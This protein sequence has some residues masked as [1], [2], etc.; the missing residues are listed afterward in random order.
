M[1]ADLND[2]DDTVGVLGT[3]VGTTVTKE[4]TTIRIAQSAGITNPAT[5]GQYPITISDDPD[6]A[7][8]D[9]VDAQNVADVIRE[10]K[11]SPTSG[12]GGADVTVTGT[13][14]GGESATVFIDTT[15]EVAADPDDDEGMPKS[16]ESNN[17]YDP[18]DD[19]NLGTVDI[20]NGKFTLVTDGIVRPS[21]DDSVGE[22]Y[23]NAI[24]GNNALVET[25]G[26]AKYEFKAGISV[27][28][29]TASWGETITVSLADWTFGDVTH[30]RFGGTNKVAVKAADDAQVEAV[31]PSGLRTGKLKVEVF[32]NT[33]NLQ[34]ASS[35]VEITPL[36][37]TISPS[38]VVPGQQI[39]ITGSGYEGTEEIDS[40]EVGTTTYTPE[41][42]STT[43]GGG[44]T[45]TVDVPLNVGTGDKTVSL[46]V[47]MRTGE[48][49]ITVAS[50]SISLSPAESL[51]GSTVQVTGSGFAADGRILLDYGTVTSLQIGQAG[52][53]GAVNMSFEVPAGAGIGA[54][55][56]VE[57]YVIGSP[58]IKADAKHSTP[59]P[60]LTTTSPVQAG[61]QMTISGSNFK[62]FSTLSDIR[63]GGQNVLPAPAPV[64][65]RQGNFEVQVQVPLLGVGSHTA[66]VADGDA[67]RGTESFSVVATIEVTSTAPA[68][69]LA[70]LGDRLVRVWY[71]ERSTQVWSFYDPDPE[72]AALGLNMTEVR[73]GQNVSIII[74]PGEPIEFQSETLYAPGPGNGT[75]PI[76]LD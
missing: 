16:Y 19:T 24:D 51:I 10:I 33:S 4:L 41:N 54:S 47:G 56:T 46:T 12:G 7:G 34:S 2:A 43:S 44:A 39:T 48:G 67:N 5:A 57:V 22:L 59:G 72:I 21:D 50:P 64:T 71:L 62:G 6:G 9:A 52:A 65:D 55:S 29:E 58:T 73:S 32:V 74:T 76:S 75:N 60:M 69:V 23:I 28:P 3:T 20:T 31:I 35:S 17:A 36:D 37:L 11:V 15:P 18:D 8:D 45:V 26:A 13:G 61:G 66:T 27:D 63:V 14:F 40:V 1:L 68:D 38:S 53:D 70:S 25:D 30:V 42:V 49:T